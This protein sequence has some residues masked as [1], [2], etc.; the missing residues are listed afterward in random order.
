MRTELHL[1]SSDTLEV[2]IRSKLAVGYWGPGPDLA[3]S[4]LKLKNPMDLEFKIAVAYFLHIRYLTVLFIIC[5]QKTWILEWR[6]WRWDGN[7]INPGFTTGIT[8]L[9]DCDYYYL[10]ILYNYYF[11]LQPTCLR[12]ELLPSE[13]PNHPSSLYWDDIFGRKGIL[14]ELCIQI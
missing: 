5:R 4:N 8:S 11:C 1:L 9:W 10:I 3:T 7:E 12:D 2:Y 13:L 14:F 6:S